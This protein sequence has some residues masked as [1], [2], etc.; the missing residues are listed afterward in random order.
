VVQI[1]IR[2]EDPTEL[3][4]LAQFLTSLSDLPRRPTGSSLTIGEAETTNVAPSA[5]APPP[6]AAVADE[7][8]VDLDMP[9]PPSGNAD[10]AYSAQQILE[11]LQDFA[12]LNGAAALRG[13]LDRFGARRVSD[14][15]PEHYA[16]VIT[17]AQGEIV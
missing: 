15:K 2:V 5:D 7:D 14:I 1:T 4:A 3:R 9:S 16:E 8:D 17:I 11:A 13:V 6:M 10:Q 12:R